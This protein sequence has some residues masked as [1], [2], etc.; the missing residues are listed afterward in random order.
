MFRHR[1]VTDFIVVIDLDEFILPKHK[2]DMTWN[3]ILKR[4]PKA[5]SYT[6]RHTAFRV[7]WNSSIASNLTDLKDRSTI[8]KLKLV[9]FSK[10]ER[11]AQMKAKTCRAKSMVNP[12]VTNMTGI[13]LVWEHT[14]GSNWIVNKSI[15]VVQHYRN[16]TGLNGT[17]DS[18]TELTA[19]KY[20]DLLIGRV[21]KVW[22][23][24]GN[25]S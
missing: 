23:D 24:I 16:R 20:K 13:H 11:E 22:Q 6:F 17:L 21:Q 1:N 4:L 18:V 9:V 5:S 2:S 8:E 19:M 15:A 12:K 14:E 3:D 25:D 7:D 10:F